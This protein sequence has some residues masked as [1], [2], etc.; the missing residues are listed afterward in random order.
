MVALD[1]LHTGLCTKQFEKR[2]DSEANLSIDGVSNTGAPEYPSV[3]YRKWSG[4]IN[5]ILGG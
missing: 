4:V 3:A 1:G 2:V 5:R